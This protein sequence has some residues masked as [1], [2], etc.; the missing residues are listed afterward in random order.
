MVETH[1][2]Q[3]KKT[4]FKKSIDFEVCNITNSQQWTLP[5]VLKLAADYVLE[6]EF[7]I[8]TSLLLLKSIQSFWFKG[9]LQD[10]LETQAPEGP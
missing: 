3:Y 5:S 8:V 2:F 1:T 7:G 9:T 4:P 10:H 6:I